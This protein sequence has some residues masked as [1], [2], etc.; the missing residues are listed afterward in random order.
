MIDPLHPVGTIQ[1]WIPTLTSIWMSILEVVLEVHTATPSHA[2]VWC[3]QS[4]V[5]GY[6]V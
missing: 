6:L 4:F 1:T 3:F 2:L 5:S